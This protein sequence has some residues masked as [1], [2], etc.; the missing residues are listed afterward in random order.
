LNV[1]GKFIAK[2]KNAENKGKTVAEIVAMWD[3]DNPS[4]PVED[5]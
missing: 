1:L 4:D 5:P 3:T 2:V